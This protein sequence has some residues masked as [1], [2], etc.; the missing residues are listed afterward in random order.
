MA[1]VTLTTFDAAVAAFEAKIRELLFLQP[2]REEMDRQ[3]AALFAQISPSI[4][5]DDV[6]SAVLFDDVDALDSP[7]NQ[8]VVSS[9]LNRA[10]VDD[11]AKHVDYLESVVLGAN[12]SAHSV[13]SSAVF[14]GSHFGNVSAPVSNLFV[15]TSV[16]TGLVSGAVGLVSGG[17]YLASAVDDYL[18]IKDAGTGGA[19]RVAADLGVADAT[20]GLAGTLNSTIQTG[21]VLGYLSA[22]QPANA[23]AA[24]SYGLVQG[25]SGAT[26]GASTAATVAGGLAAGAGAVLSL[27]QLGISAYNF[28]QTVKGWQAAEAAGTP[29]SETTIALA[30]TSFALQTVTGILGVATGIST[31]IFPP[32]GLILGVVTAVVAA[33][34]F[35]FDL[36]VKIFTY[37]A[38]FYDHPYFG[39]TNGDDEVVHAGLRN[40]N[41][42]TFG[43]D[44]N[45]SIQNAGTALPGLT[46]SVIDG[47]ADNDTLNI[48]NFTHSSIYDHTVNRITTYTFG[49]GHGTGNVGTWI[50]YGVTTNPKSYEQIAGIN[51]IE[52]LIGSKQRDH[53]TGNPEGNILL[54]KEHND[55]L[56]GGDG[57]D[58]LSGGA[59]VDEFYGGRDID[60]V[61][62]SIDD[63]E[64]ATQGVDVDLV[65]EIMIN[66]STGQV[67]D[68]VFE[69]IENLV[70][71]KY[72]DRL[73][74][75][76]VGN[77][78]AG[79]G[80]NDYLDGAAGK[81]TLFGGD[82]NDTIYGGSEDDLISAGIGVD[83]IYGGAGVDTLSYQLDTSE[84]A[85][86]S[87]VYI[88]LQNAFAR[89][90][91][92]SGFVDQDILSSIENAVG[93]D[94]N[95]TVL[96]SN[97]N[98]VLL[99]AKG[100]DSISG[101]RGND[102]LI[103]GAGNDTIDGGENDDVISGGA[104]YDLLRGGNGI[105][106]LHYGI[107]DD[108]DTF[109]NGKGIYLNLSTGSVRSLTSNTQL[110]EG[111]SGFENVIGTKYADALYGD[112]GKNL[113]DG[114][115]GTDFLWGDFGDDT[116]IGG[117]G[118]DYLAGLENNDLLS[119]GTGQDTLDGGIGVD[120]VNYLLDATEKKNYVS[121]NVNLATGYATISD[122][123][124]TRV[125]EDRLISIEYVIASNGNDTIDGSSVA[126][127]LFGADGS[128][129]INGA[130]GNDTV[131]GGIGNDT[132][133]G[134][135]D[136]DFLVGG[137]G[138]DSLTGGNHDDVL[139][140]EAGN[141]TL[142]GGAGN[143]TA[144]FTSAA[145]RWQID[146]VAGTA[147]SSAL[148]TGST[149]VL[150]DTLRNI[151]NVTTGLGNDTIIGSA[152]A[153]RILAGDGNDII[154][155]DAGNDV[156]AGD[157]GNDRIA[158]G[159]NDDIIVGG[160]GNDTIY[161]GN[162][163]DVAVYGEGLSAE[164]FAVYGATL[165]GFDVNLG[166]TTSVTVRA[167]STSGAT[168]ETDYVLDVEGF[169][170]SDRADRTIVGLQNINT[171][172][173]RGVDLLDFTYL[174][175][176]VA[177]YANLATGVV[178]LVTTGA[179]VTQTHLN[180]EN[181]NGTNRGD[182]I[183][184]GN[185][186][187][188]LQGFGGDDVLY[189][190]IGADTLD[191][192]SGVDTASYATALGGVTVN[193]ATG[194]V[195]GDE[196]TG[197]RLISIENVAGSRYADTLTGNS[198]ANILSGGAG[199]D[200]MFGGGGSDSFVYAP[201][202]ER[203][204]I[205][206]FASDDVIRLSGFAGA[207]SYAQILGIATQAGS[208]VILNFNATDKLVL[209]NYTV[210]QLQADDFQF[211]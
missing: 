86:Y 156:I 152:G 162:H 163:H 24:W 173:A 169:L 172:A 144:T 96:G 120:T 115:D 34:S 125:N 76:G 91:R 157:A 95:D 8:A 101:G 74:G 71:T 62:Y 140:G 83:D 17:L 45:I 191:G 107:A 170:L 102:A 47:G 30:S 105:D 118:N 211:A 43:G 160:L 168:L 117:S 63:G 109:Q 73:T 36:F 150:E 90:I 58:T 171:D 42:S 54:G 53:F 77:F 32:L 55:T 61:N 69:S 197:D 205:R 48:N 82:G 99:G 13:I 40:F 129:R 198:G 80:G 135:D 121:I 9:Y 108:E 146:L 141:D 184:G 180:Y 155:S 104:G 68:N 106:T 79:V 112:G 138:N 188:H 4:S 97:D 33:I 132:I 127:F 178:T 44:D 87:S 59:G 70:G 147:R 88:D 46:F 143:D 200:V 84:V 16:L 110:D 145:V 133:D 15:K 111:F 204:T 149:I 137:D 89:N 52:N 27:A 174:A 202:G 154:S 65:R 72:N 66:R 208:D 207:T 181:V 165:R 93:S 182:V 166:S 50:V 5:S 128:D 114:G 10:A 14:A 136:H 167:I 94:G 201:G 159:D 60:T 98:N 22:G 122:A 51:Y 113:L 103:G 49:S 175:N 81:D 85:G 7:L 134:G 196:A 189:G 41:V 210:G 31:V 161:G 199:I 158:A 177:V 195:S 100:N 187:N 56:Y 176:N 29:V 124:G 185:S 11:A 19:D 18:Q 2:T 35:I 25:V 37:E 183:I 12:V 116:L 57:D 131:I 142:D 153:N 39:G 151:E 193:L 119:G 126:N 194:A 186:A 209:S 179:N 130:A 64:G 23:W 75:D 148:A 1:T 203:D 206:D 38:P 6:F 3:F 67:E 139:S 26:T 28:S 78:L 92:T 123:S 192:G 164:Q 21:I 20:L 190:G